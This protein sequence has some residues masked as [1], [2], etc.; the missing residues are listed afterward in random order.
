MKVLHILYSGLGGHGNVFFSMVDADKEKKL[1]QE[2]LFF[3]IEEIREGYIENANAR[4]IPW[5][6]VKKKPGLDFS[7]YRQIRTIIKRSAPDII[8]I[9]GGCYIYPAKRAA[10]ASSKKMKIVVRETKPNHLKTKQDWLGLVFSLL[11]AHKVVFLSNEYKEAIR[12]KFSLFFSKKRTAVIPNGIDLDAYKP[13]PKKKDEFIKIGMQSRLSA[14]KDHATLIKAFHLCLQKNPT[15]KN[16][17]LFIAGE[18]E[19]KPGLEALTKELKIEDKIVFTGML[20]EKDLIEFINSLNIYV[21][22]SLGETMSTAIMQVMACQLPIIASDVLG[23]NNMIK[24]N[25]NGILVP[26]ADE[27]ELANAILYLLNNPDTAAKLAAA[28]YD[29]AINN[30]SNNIMLERYKAVFAE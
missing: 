25:S 3:G 11:V 22:A 1:K 8:F 18:G 27:Q 28:A 4:N 9:H 7:S 10:I 20:E 2:A 13:H 24:H 19:C 16:L 14:T 15:E 12:K 30:Y 23:V 5:Y 21:H 17:W 29:F 26:A 6:F